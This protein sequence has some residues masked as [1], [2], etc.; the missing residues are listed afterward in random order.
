[1]PG[2]DGLGESQPAVKGTKKEEMED[3][4]VE[5]TVWGQG[6]EESGET[7]CTGCM[8]HVV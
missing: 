6:G 4:T 1:M 8:K 2:G 7:G 5:M 3:D